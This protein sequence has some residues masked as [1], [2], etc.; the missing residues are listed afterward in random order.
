ME[1]VFLLKLLFDIYIFCFKAR[2]T[3]NKNWRWNT[4]Y[5]KCIRFQKIISSVL[6]ICTFCK[7]LLKLAVNF[8]IS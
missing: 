1:K 4:T 5:F 2:L 6:F 3:Y 8:N 7:L